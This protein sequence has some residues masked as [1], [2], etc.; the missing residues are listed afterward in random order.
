MSDGHL[1]LFAPHLYLFGVS[2]A[3]SVGRDGFDAPLSEDGPALHVAPFIII[4]LARE[5]PMF[6]L[7]YV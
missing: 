4:S 6:S 3:A 2:V 5:I 7:V 1:R